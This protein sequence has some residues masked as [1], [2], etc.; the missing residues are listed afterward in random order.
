MNRWKQN[1][2]RWYALGLA[3]VLTA[4]CLVLATGTVWARYRAVYDDTLTFQTRAPVTLR[5]GRTDPET[6]GFTAGDPGPWVV[7][8]GG[9]RLDFAVSNGTDPERFEAEDQT[10]RIRLV[11]SLGMDAETVAIRLSDPAEN[12][13][14]ETEAGEQGYT[15]QPVRIT[16]SSPLYQSFGD[17]WVYRFQNEAGQEL[18]WTLEGGVFSCVELELRI[19]SLDGGQIDTSLMQLQLIGETENE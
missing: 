6:N 13:G 7:E 9:L 3:A 17:G 18:A 14:E 1:I 16:E 10:F 15:A 19:V 5:L 4:A 8:D 12:A 11:T 2:S